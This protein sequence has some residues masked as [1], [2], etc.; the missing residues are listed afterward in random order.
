MGGTNDAGT[1]FSVSPS[2][3]ETLVYSFKSG[4]DGATPT[5][6]LVN[7]KGILY[8]TTSNGGNAQ[9][10]VF[11]ITPA[12]LERT[13]HSFHGGADGSLPL[14][15]L[16]YV[17]DT[18]YGTTE[19]GG[20]YG[21][22]T[23]FSIKPNGK[24]KVLYSF[25]ASGDGASPFASL[26][27]AGG[28]LYGTTLYGGDPSCNQGHG[29]G[30]VF[31]IS[32]QGNETVLYAFRSG[33]D[34][35]YPTCSL[36]ALNGRF[37]GTTRGGGTHGGGTIF[38]ITPGGAENIIYSFGGG[39]DG[40]DP[41]AA[42]IN[43]NNKLYGTTENGGTNGTAFAIST[44]GEETWLYQF[45]PNQTPPNRNNGSSPSTALVKL[46]GVLYGTAQYG[47]TSNSGTVFSI[48][49]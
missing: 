7:V 41:E 30:V 27:Y 14:A 42:L 12:G 32:L 5:A 23:V 4:A 17:G 6:N 37:Y 2:G 49:P 25:G 31:S 47:G 8:G 9:G 20:K 35:A 18:F 29:C 26:I 16:R 34:A 36:L 11:S 45:P 15:G 44:G 22:G 1:V 21:A 3:A 38:T 43:V 19:F 28:N 46:N 33:N 24:E 40:Y 48:N 39:G 10:T 13:L